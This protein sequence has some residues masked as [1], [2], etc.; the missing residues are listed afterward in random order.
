MSDV[1]N[2]HLHEKKQYPGSHF[3]TQP[4]YLPESKLSTFTLPRNPGQIEENF[5]ISDQPSF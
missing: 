2:R 4:Y 3:N 1:F 5:N